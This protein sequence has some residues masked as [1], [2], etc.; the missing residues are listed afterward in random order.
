MSE[1]T[2]VHAVSSDRPTLLKTALTLVFALSLLFNLF[3]AIGYAQARRQAAS[4]SV[5]AEKTPVG[6]QVS[7]ALELDQ[8]QEE[9]YQSL[10]QRLRAVREDTMAD[11]RAVQEELAAALQDPNP[12]RER[13]QQAMDRIDAMG[14][15][16]REA[17]IQTLREF[18]DVLNTEQQN[19]LLARLMF[20]PRRGG[21]RESTESLRRSFDADG[22]GTLSDE[23][24][25]N[26]H[27]DMQRR[28][29]ERKERFEAQR[30]AW[31]NM[32]AKFDANGDG[33]LDDA[34]MQA[35]REWRR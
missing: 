31:K 2:E 32:H 1:S 21:G 29:Q 11:M 26:L 17:E 19:A 24:W 13:M 5:P 28:H 22:D 18:L 15:A 9:V 25:S 34:E 23:E 33:E 6:V 35:L 27:R 4:T 14:R 16:L 10:R 7:E 3:F 20:N 12:D 30:E 8:P